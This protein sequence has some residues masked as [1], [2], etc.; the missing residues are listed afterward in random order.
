MRQEERIIKEF[1]RLYGQKD[2]M[3]AIDRVSFKFPGQ[4]ETEFIHWDSN[5]YEWLNEPYEGYQGFLALSST[6]FFAV[7]RTHTIAFREE[8]I[9][10]YPATSRKDQYLIRKNADPLKLQNKVVEYKLEPGDLVIWSNRLLHEARKNKSQTIRYG[11]YITYFPHDQ[12]HPTVIKQ[13]K[14]KKLD[15]KDDRIRS[16]EEGKNPTFFPSGT[17]VRLWARASLMYHPDKLN[18]FCEMFTTGSEIYVYKS[19]VKKGKTV[20]LPIEW[21]PKEL[22]FYEPPPLSEVGR[23]LLGYE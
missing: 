18:K 22:G 15:W 20:K 5:P 13:Y 19:G 14:N 8:F 7:P 2:L 3:V 10:H 4:G 16:Y 6:S 9:K 11:Y 17:E 12:P 21:N 23:K 1:Q